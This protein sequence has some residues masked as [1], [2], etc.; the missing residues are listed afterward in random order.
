[1]T[2]GHGRPGGTSV[3]GARR[4]Y[5]MGAR[6]RAVEQTRER[7]L[8]VAV[9]E[10]WARPSARVSLDQVAA[11]AG[12]STQ[13]VI[14]HFGGAQG[15]FVAAVEREGAR[16]SAHR[17]A[18]VVR[19]DPAAAVAQLVEHYEEYGDAVIRLLAEETR[20]PALAPVVA[21]GRALH[22]TWCESAFPSALDGLRPTQRGQRLALLVTVCDVHTWKLLRRDSGLSRRRTEQAM[23][24]LV[25]AVVGG[26]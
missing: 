11:S 14:R 17:D 8:D 20:Q 18:A 22:R 25:V 9:A 23:R 24:D 3:E 15:L 16:V 7:I 12:V 5:R 6:A 19:D 13:T 2:T 1:M 4:T 10:F 26:M 21:S